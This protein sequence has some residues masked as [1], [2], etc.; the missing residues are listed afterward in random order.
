[1][2][3]KTPVIMGLQRFLF[4]Q[5]RILKEVAEIIYMRKETA[6]ARFTQNKI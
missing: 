6:A 5:S 4:F 2:S 3:G 1:M